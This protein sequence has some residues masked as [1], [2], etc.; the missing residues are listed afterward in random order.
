MEKRCNLCPRQCNADRDIKIGYCGESNSV[1]L[2][3]AALHM[4]EEPCISGENGSGAVF[5]TGCSLRCIFCQNNKIAD[6]SIGKKVSID[7]LAKTFLKLQDQNAANI[8]LVTASHFIPQVVEAL[9][10][11]KKDG[12]HIPIVYNCSGYENIEALKRLNGVIDIYLPDMKYYNP[13]LSQNFSNAPDYFHVASKAIEEMVSQVKAPVFDDNGMM[14]QGVIVRHLI[15]PAHTK[16]SCNII[17][18]LYQNYGDNIYI[19]I[20]NQFTPVIHQEKFVELNRKLT[21]REYSNVIDYALSLGVT[22]AFI[23]EGGTAKE[24]FIPSFD[25]EG[26]LEQKQ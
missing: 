14:R 6:G 7:D 21:K 17:K 4:W 8:N 16:D 10:Q 26:V 23:Q 19:S 18:Y 5:F 1:R 2:A 20:M 12:L 13:I 9:Y 25:Y 15:L 24:S 11:A 22:N 3:R